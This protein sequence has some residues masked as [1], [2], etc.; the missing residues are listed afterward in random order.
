MI[1]IIEIL[2]SIVCFCI[3][4]F[5]IFRIKL[6]VEENKIIKKAAVSIIKQEFK[7]DKD[8]VRKVKK[9]NNLQDYK[10]A[11]RPSDEG[12]GKPTPKRLGQNEDGQKTS[13]F[14]FPFFKKK[15]RE[16]PI[17]YEE[18]IKQHLR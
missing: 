17:E 14:K 10:E 12:E 16:T 7:L 8:L 13:K 1:G 4:W 9:Y 11:S 5:I 3:I 15:Y 6:K 18:R 2:F